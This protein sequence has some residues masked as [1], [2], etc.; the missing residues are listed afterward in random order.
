[1]DE[2]CDYYDSSGNYICYSIGRES[3]DEMEM[4]KLVSWGLILFQ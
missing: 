4:V 2:Y 3:F 1:M